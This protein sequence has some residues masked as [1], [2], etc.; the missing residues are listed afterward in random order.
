MLVSFE[1]K[2]KIIANAE[3]S[4]PVHYDETITI[5]GKMYTSIDY[6]HEVEIKMK[7]SGK[8]SVV[9]KIICM[10]EEYKE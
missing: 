8:K 2:G 3:L 10:V 7:P 4:L 5:F 9:E 1:Y 6:R